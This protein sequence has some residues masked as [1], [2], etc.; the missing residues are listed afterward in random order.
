MTAGFFSALDVPILNGREFTDAEGRSRSPVAIVNRTMAKR[1]WPDESAVGR[2]FRWTESEGEIWFTVVGVSED[3]LTWDLSYRPLPAA[4]LPYAY[5]P[6]CDP[7]M[8]VRASGDAAALA[9]PARAAVPAADPC[10]RM[11]QRRCR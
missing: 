3:I 10:G 6:V 5:V 11:G 8:L 1:F 4:Y 7:T 9:S 2:A